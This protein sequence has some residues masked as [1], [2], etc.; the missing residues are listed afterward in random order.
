VETVFRV[1]G[2]GFVAVW[3]IGTLGN[4]GI[5]DLAP[6]QALLAAMFLG[7]APKGPI[8]AAALMGASFA[9]GAF[10]LRNW[11]EMGSVSDREWRFYGPGARLPALVVAI[12]MVF[13]AWVAY[14]QPSGRDALLSVA[15][16][17]LVAWFATTLLVYLPWFS[18]TELSLARKEKKGSVL[19]RYKLE[20]LSENAEW[21][22]WVPDEKDGEFF[23]DI[24]SARLAGGMLVSQGEA[25]IVQVTVDVKHQVLSVN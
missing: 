12:A 10:T 15:V 8:G 11:R 13:A 4:S 22:T 20:R 14:D 7:H 6:V 24:L 5:F 2:I 1:L 3:V 9:S 16:A 18:F 17:A 19:V 21:V 23:D 25:R